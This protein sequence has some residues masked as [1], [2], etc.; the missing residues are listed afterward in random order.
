MTMSGVPG[1]SSPGLTVPAMVDWLEWI[2]ADAEIC[3]SAE[4]SAD[5]S[6]TAQSA[7][8]LVLS[9]QSAAEITLTGESQSCC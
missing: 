2:G 4:T 5:I 8:E 3:I 9:G 7:A 1:V 6:I